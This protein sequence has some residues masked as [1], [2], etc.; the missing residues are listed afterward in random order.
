MIFSRYHVTG[1]SIFSHLSDNHV[2]IML[3]TNTNTNAFIDEI[4]L[5]SGHHV[6]GHVPQ[7]PDRRQLVPRQPRCS[8]HPRPH[9]LCPGL[10]PPG[11][12]LLMLFVKI[13]LSWGKVAVFFVSCAS[14]V[15]STRYKC[16]FFQ[17]V[18]NTWIFGTLMCSTVIF[19]QVLFRKHSQETPVSLNETKIDRL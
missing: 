12:N 8:G 4:S 2:L 15:C 13:F 10:D 17:D 1:L 14:Y 11:I 19:S 5:H 9:N 7:P 6:R 16:C 3:L 18:T